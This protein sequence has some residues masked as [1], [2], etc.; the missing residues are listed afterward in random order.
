MIPI[1]ER[2]TFSNKKFE[3]AEKFLN[4]LIQDLK[5]LKCSNDDIEKKDIA[6]KVQIHLKNLQHY[7]A[8]YQSLKLICKNIDKIDKRWND[9]IKNSFSI[10]SLNEITDQTLIEFEGKL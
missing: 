10:E 9:V 3:D 8:A 1:N 5:K 6:M 2:I 4:L 7:K